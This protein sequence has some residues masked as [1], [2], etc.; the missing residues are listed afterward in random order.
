MV[1]PFFDLMVISF[2][3]M[4]A[5]AAWFWLARWKKMDVFG[6]RPVLWAILIASPFGLLAQEFGWLVTEFGRQPWIAHGAM[7]VS[8]GV[9]PAP[10]LWM[11]VVFILVYAALTAGL[12][13][14]LLTPAAIK[15]G[16]PG[17]RR[18]PG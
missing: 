5:A 2:F 8:Q 13:K 11:L 10:T 4:S 12:L 17:D 18:Y 3:I 14:L 6:R 9:T 16:I 15:S 1:H 7:L